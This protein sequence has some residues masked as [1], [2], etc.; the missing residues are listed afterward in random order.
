VE[1]FDGIS[2]KNVGRRNGGREERARER[3]RKRE[4]NENLTLHPQGPGEVADERTPCR[5]LVL[6][7]DVEQH[8]GEGGSVDLENEWV[9]LVLGGDR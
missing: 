6:G 7:P 8:V 3:E 4:R 1:F 2:G 5:C 9:F